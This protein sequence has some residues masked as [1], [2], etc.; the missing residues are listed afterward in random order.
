MNT[1]MDAVLAEYSA[2]DLELLV[3]FLQRTT[4]AGQTATS[5]LAEA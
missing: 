2:A 4:A 3:D 5:E 1:T